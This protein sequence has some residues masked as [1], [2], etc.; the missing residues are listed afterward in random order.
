MAE[1]TEATGTEIAEVTVFTN[2]ATEKTETNGGMDDWRSEGLPTAARFAGLSGARE[3]QT[4][5]AE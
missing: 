3:S 5:A 4:Q 2:G 1:V